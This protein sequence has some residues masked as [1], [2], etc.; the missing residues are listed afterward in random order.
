MENTLDLK[1]AKWLVQGQIAGK[2]QTWAANL[3][4]LIPNPVLLFLHLAPDSEFEL[5]LDRES[6]IQNPEFWW[7]PAYLSD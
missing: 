1:R 4:F 7:G 3:Y 5:A 2:W 6:Q